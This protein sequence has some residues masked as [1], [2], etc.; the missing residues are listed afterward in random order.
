MVV[1]TAMAPSPPPLLTPTLSPI[2]RVTLAVRVRQVGMLA[3]G[4]GTGGLGTVRVVA[5][6]EVVEG[7]GM[8]ISTTMTP[9]SQSHLI[10]IPTH[11]HRFFCVKFGYVMFEALHIQVA[12]AAPESWEEHAM[13]EAPSGERVIEE[14]GTGME[15][16]GEGMSSAA[17]GVERVEGRSVAE[18]VEGATE[19]VERCADVHPHGSRAHPTRAPSHGSP[20]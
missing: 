15:V 19:Q 7:G 3:V 9:P 4:P 6:Y 20:P 5:S 13:Q 2:T 16:E 12:E 1:S 8:V 17:A 14:G 18:G 11:I 10:P